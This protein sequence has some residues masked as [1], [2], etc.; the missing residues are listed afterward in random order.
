[1]RTFLEWLHQNITAAQAALLHVLM[2]RDEL[3]YTEAP[4]IYREYMEKIG[5]FEREAIEKELDTILLEKKERMIQACINRRE[6]IDLEKIDA[7]LNQE[8]EQLL[9]QAGL[10]QFQEQKNLTPEEKEELRKLYQEIVKKF[11]PSVC[12][13][14]ND[15]QKALFNSATLQRQHSLSSLPAYFSPSLTIL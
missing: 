6:K 11:H 5:H 8:K 3:K 9:A 4:K 12:P 13:D 14:L 7:Q 2:Y 10:H 15:T 1:M